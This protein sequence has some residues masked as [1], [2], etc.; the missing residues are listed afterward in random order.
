MSIKNQKSTSLLLLISLCNVFSFSQSKMVTVANTSNMAFTNKVVE[1]P[2]AVVKN[3]FGTID[4][5]NLIVMDAITKKQI[6]FQFETG[7]SNTIKNLL[8]EISLQPKQNK[9]LILAYGKRAAF[10]QK[11]FARYVPERKEDFAWEN[12]KIAFRMYGKE[13][14]KTPKEMGYGMDVW[15]K[16]TDRMIL[17]ERYKRAEYHI[18]H[19]DGMDYY[20]VG[21]SMGAGSMMPYLEDSTWYSKNYS[22]YK[23]LDNG[24]LRTTFQLFYNEWQVGYMNL[25]AIKTITLDAGSQLNKINVQ[26]NGC[27]DTVLPVVAGI[28]LRKGSDVKY[29]DKIGGVMTYWEPQHG[30]DGT[31]GVACI[32]TSP[33]LQ[34]KEL[35]GQLLG[36]T[37]TDRKHSVTY[38]AGAAWD[39]AGFITNAQHWNRYILDFKNQ[40]NNQALIKIY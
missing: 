14:E 10:S 16:S 12:D 1:L 3:K 13:L 2:W 35:N 11:T 28:V 20:H 40:L 38:Y 31:T 21:L 32:F 6:S 5:A 24:P 17:N 23:I 7:G 22:S 34:M 33:I 8:V 27:K 15:V 26:Y 36:I 37:S 29:Q 39:K 9:Q 18:D 4:T 30:L 25:T 19:G